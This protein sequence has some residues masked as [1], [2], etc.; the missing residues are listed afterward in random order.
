MP[1]DSLSTD[2]LLSIFNFYLQMI[3][4]NIDHVIIKIDGQVRGIERV[5]SSQSCAIANAGAPSTAQTVHPFMSATAVS[6]HMTDIWSKTS[7]AFREF[8]H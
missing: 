8:H 2:A 5:D 4:Y 6:P 3:N 7:L 1:Y